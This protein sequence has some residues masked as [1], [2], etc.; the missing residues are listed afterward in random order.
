MIRKKISIFSDDKVR[1]NVRKGISV[2]CAITILIVGMDFFNQLLIKKN[3]LKKYE[4]FF[5]GEQE[6]DVLFL[7]HLMCKWVFRY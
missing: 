6:Y 2:V 4:P 5:V 3:S 7:V 1:I